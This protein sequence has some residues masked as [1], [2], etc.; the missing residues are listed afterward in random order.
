[1]K[2]LVIVLVICILCLFIY[3]NPDLVKTTT[4]EIVKITDGLPNPNEVAEVR[5]VDI[6]TVKISVDE[7]P[8]TEIIYNK[9][10]KLWNEADQ[11][12]NPIT[13][14][15]QALGVKTET[16][17][18]SF[19]LL[20][21][22]VTQTQFNQLKENQVLTWWMTSGFQGWSVYAH[23][24][25][26][27]VKSK[28]KDSQCYWRS[29]SG[30]FNSLD[31]GRL[32]ELLSK[33]GDVQTYQNLKLGLTQYFPSSHPQGPKPFLEEVD[34]NFEV[35]F[36]DPGTITNTTLFGK[37]IIG[38]AFWEKLAKYPVSLKA[39]KYKEDQALKLTTLATLANGRTQGEVFIQDSPR[40]TVNIWAKLTSN[41]PITFQ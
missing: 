35:Y 28:S 13:N 33:L 25:G 2:G 7:I 6:Y 31:C 14:I 3:E 38:K 40:D 22:R 23:W 20:E 9:L 17:D 27:W 30:Q 4:R 24:R 36:Q 18:T 1:M 37:E 26:V 39:I 32:N 8:I 16:L 12:F 10:K 21:V 11:K 41:T 15:K 29:R 5:K 19:K 34:F